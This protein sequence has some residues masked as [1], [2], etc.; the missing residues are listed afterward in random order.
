MYYFLAERFT[1][2]T[3]LAPSKANV[4]LTLDIFPVGS[5]NWS[6][7]MDLNWL[8]QDIIFIFSENQ[9]KNGLFY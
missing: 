3:F 6:F 7:Y 2:V 8:T 4:C 1:E 5:F 9:A